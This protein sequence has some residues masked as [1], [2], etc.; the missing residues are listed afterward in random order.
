MRIS[1]QE[2]QYIKELVLKE[3]TTAKTYLFGSR[4]DDSKNGGDIDILIL[5]DNHLKAEQKSKIRW[6]FYEKHGE[7]KLDLVN[8]SFSEKS[9]FKE[10]ILLDAVEI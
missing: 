3:S 6:A 2:L 9:K 5:S 10:L 4:L 1:K 8:F 7:Q